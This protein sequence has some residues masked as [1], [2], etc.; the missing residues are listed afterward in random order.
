MQCTWKVGGGAPPSLLPADVVGAGDDGGAAVVQ[1]PP[2]LTDL[3][4]TLLLSEPH[5]EEALAF[6]HVAEQQHP[7]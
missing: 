7:S 1:P 4:P 3:Q 5:L 6:Q 2:L